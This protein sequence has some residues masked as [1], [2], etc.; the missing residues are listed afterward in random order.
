MLLRV[1]GL[2]KYFPVYRGVFS[3]VAGWVRAVDGVSLSIG[4]GETLGLVG[5]SGSGKTTLGKTV[6]RL[7]EPT[8]GSVWFEERRMDGLG[9]EEL[10]RLRG[11][12]QII[13]QD[14][15][16]SLDPRMTVGGSVG[17]PLKV[18]RGARGAYLDEAVER[19]LE[20]VGLPAAAVNRYPHELSGGQRQRVGVARALALDPSLIVCDEPVSALD[21]SIQAQIINLLEDLQEEMGLSYLF[22]SHDLRVVEHISDRVAVM[23]CGEIIEAAARDDLYGK[24][25]HPYTR[26]LLEAVPDV[27]RRKG[28]V[29]APEGEVPSPLAPP[30]GCRFHPRCRRRMPVCS[31]ERP[32]MIAVEEGREVACWLYGE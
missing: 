19:L 6:L 14:P 8:S 27:G 17:E 3:R 23:Y 20:K 9:A 11:R 2:K 1:E 32:A 15:V 25:L 5:E 31:R 26:A 7:L 16:S 4:R 29:E 18:H 22:I 24:P 13:F 12:M 21:V 28:P 30:P 10:R